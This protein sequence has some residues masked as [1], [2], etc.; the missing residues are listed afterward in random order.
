[1]T[2]QT[3]PHITADAGPTGGVPTAPHPAGPSSSITGPVGGRPSVWRRVP[4]TV[5]IA[6]VFAGLLVL[7]AFA[8]GVLATHDPRAITLDSPLAAPSW[9]HWFGTDQSGRDLYS[10]IVHGTAQSLLIGLGSAAVGVGLAVVFGSWAALGGRWADAVIG[11]A[12]EVLFAFPIL[13]LAMV[14]IAVYGPSVQTLILAV[15][16][17]IAP[18]YARM[19]RAQ[20]MSVRRS[21]Y[22]QAAQA[23]GH[24]PGRVLAQHI[25]PNALRPLLAVLT[26]GIGQSIVWASGLAFLG[27][28]VAP[29]SP[30]WGALL[31]AGRP[32][33]IEAWWL[34]IIPGL[35]VLATALTAT[36]LGKFVESTLEGER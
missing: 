1:M 17:G 22:V 15:G 6:G 13:L 2:A 35:A 7:A 12:I 20:V 33:I 16:L 28:G 26:L 11:R 24:H 31:E 29:P 27:F 3:Q 8:P 21:G 30:E 32:Y 25:L 19:V 4:V 5:W 10:R 18:G 36:V 14:F 9:E 23:L 34:E